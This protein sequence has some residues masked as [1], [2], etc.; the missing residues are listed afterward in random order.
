MTKAEKYFGGYQ[1]I[2]CP[3][4]IKEVCDKEIVKD[5]GLIISK[6]VFDDGSYVD[7]YGN[8]IVTVNGKYWYND[9][10]AVKPED[11]WAINMAASL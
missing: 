4:L 8:E 10:H 9:E 6:L 7:I 2:Y 3:K 11:A 5:E 1:G